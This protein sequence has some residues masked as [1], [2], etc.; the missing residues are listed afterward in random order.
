MRQSRQLEFHLATWGGRR[1][2]AGRKPAPGRRAV[3]HSRRTP[4]GPR[5][6]AHVTLRAAVGLTSLRERRLF[7]AI[8]AAFGAASKD[9]FRL[10]HYSVQSDHLHLLVEAD[11]ATALTR[12]VQGL[13]IRVAKAINRVLGRH[14]VVWGDRFHARALRTPREVRNALVYVLNNW[15]KH[16]P[17][18]RGL[19]AYSSAAWFDGWQTA[20]AT[21][22][23]T[24]PVARARTWLA[25][26]GWRR[27]GLLE[28]SEEPR[29]PKAL[30]GDSRSNDCQ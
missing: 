11:E 18:A 30:R 26:I 5:C 29:R 6:P 21:T 8:R 7:A 25:R 1:T 27:H 12:G 22:M 16:I 19:D 2:G 3:P 10:L 13:A 20:V 17:G 4:H 23:A 28:V 14:G 9:A 24:P 15:R